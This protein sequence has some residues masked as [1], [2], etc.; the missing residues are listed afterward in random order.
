MNDKMNDAARRVQRAKGYRAAQSV[1]PDWWVKELIVRERLT[2]L[3]PEPFLLRK[4]DAELDGR[5]RAERTEAGVREIL[6]EFNRR[7]I[8]ARRQLLGGPP[9]I[10]RTRDIDAEVARWRADRSGSAGAGS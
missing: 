1:D 6:E 3:A 7:V 9:V 2:G 5:L 8:N 10:T 4:D